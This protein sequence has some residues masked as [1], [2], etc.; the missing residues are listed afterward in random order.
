MHP[1]QSPRTAKQLKEGGQKQEEQATG[2]TGTLGL[3][4]GTWARLA[5][6]RWGA[7]HPPYGVWAPLPDNR[8][9]PMITDQWEECIFADYLAFF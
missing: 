6:L 1:S 9:Q 7:N 5:I 3:G 4:E 8:G 2:D